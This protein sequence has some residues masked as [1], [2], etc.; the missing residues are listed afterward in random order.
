MDVK[1]ALRILWKD[2][3]TVIEYHEH[4]KEN[5]S[6]VHQEV[7]VL[8][9]EQC[10]LSFESLQPVN[11]TD[12]T[13]GIVQGAKLFIDE[14]LIIKP[15]SKVIITQTSTGRVYEFKQSGKAGVFE[16]HQEIALV[17]YEDFA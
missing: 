16:N 12:T 11:Q 15:G 7:T 10:K 6:T 14:G 9:D 8:E 4:A 3:C 1:T 5:K 2:T 13:A 17:P